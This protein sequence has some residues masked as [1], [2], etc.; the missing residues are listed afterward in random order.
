MRIAI[1]CNGRTLTAWQHR[2]I[3]LI[4]DGNELFLLVCEDPPARRNLWR[5]GLYYLLN[6]GTVRRANRTVPFPNGQQI[7]GRFDF[8]PDQRGAWSALPEAALDWIGA[9]RIDAI[10]KFGLKLLTVPEAGKLAAP[11][12]SYHHGDPRGFRGRPAGFHE[13]MQDEPFLGQVVQ[14]LSNRLDSGEVLA[15]A[16]SRVSPHSYRRTLLDAY[17]LSPLLLPQALAALESRTRLPIEPTGANYRLP[18]NSKALRF[19]AGRAVQLARRLI[20]GAFIEKHWRVSTAPA[21]NVASP[22]AAIDQ[23]NS[24]RSNWR[25]IPIHPPHRF[26]ADPFFH[27]D[28]GTML[29]EAMNG[30][31]GKGEL[32]RVDGRQQQRVDGLSGHISYPAGVEE[33][34]RTYIVP[35]TCGWSRPAIFAVEKDRAVRVADL[36]IDEDSILDPTLLR[37]EGRLYLFGNRASEGPAI[38]RL[39]S[40]DHLFARFEPHPASPIRTSIRGGRMAGPIHRWPDGLFRL[41]QDFRSGYGDGIVAFRIDELTPDRYAEAEAGSASFDEV[42]GPHTLDMR[43]GELLFDWYDERLSLL[44]GARRLLNRL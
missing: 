29:V 42:R 23:A 22:L 7:A 13:L 40:A 31:T 20:Y 41:G 25:T 3:E 24:S 9:N 26:H 33:K 10:V 30:L 43:D 36:D 17:S 14:V 35:E 32:L 11:I 27:G 16:Q 37:H 12:L 6:L 4:A 2:A 8:V 1:I 15:F 38:L 28:D 18:N 39:W 19:M 5:H 21:G 34:E 44:A